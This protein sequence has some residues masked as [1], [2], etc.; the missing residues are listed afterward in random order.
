M[1]VY[2]VIE[3]WGYGERDIREVFNSYEKAEKFIYEKYSIK[4]K[5]KI[6]ETGDYVYETIYGLDIWI[7]EWEV[8]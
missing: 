7:D 8:K 6:L 3:D 5:R 4:E 1:K 2:I